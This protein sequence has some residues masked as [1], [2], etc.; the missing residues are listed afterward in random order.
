MTEAF[1]LPPDYSYR[2]MYLSDLET[3]LHIEAI[4]NPSP[5]Q[6]THF[7]SS[8]RHNLCWVIEYQRTVIGYAV[9]RITADEAELL[10]IAI[11][12]HHRQ[13]GLAQFLLNQLTHYAH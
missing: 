7:Q 11:H 4:D 5:W 1:T 6:H 13:R 2:A 9:L 8:L 3:V 10:N 12:P